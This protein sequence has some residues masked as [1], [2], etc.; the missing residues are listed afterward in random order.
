MKLRQTDI[1]FDHKIAQGYKIHG[2]AYGWI[3]YT[4]DGKVVGGQDPEYNH[5]WVPYRKTTRPRGW[6]LCAGEYTPEQ[7]NNKMYE[8]TGGFREGTYEWFCVPPNKHTK[9]Y[10]SL[11]YCKY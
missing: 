4:L 7:F 10:I 3:L 8:G 11:G 6:K 2:G 9:G 5:W 1:L